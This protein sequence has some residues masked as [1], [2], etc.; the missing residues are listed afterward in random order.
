MK[1]N[2]FGEPIFGP[3]D[4]ADDIREY[5][6]APY[7]AR[8]SFEDHLQWSADI[9]TADGAVVH[10]Y[11]FSS[12]ESLISWLKELGDDDVEIEASE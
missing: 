8:Y 3:Q 1:I 7:T 9:D 5:G 12:E 10:A 6:D 11:N 4:H 2:A